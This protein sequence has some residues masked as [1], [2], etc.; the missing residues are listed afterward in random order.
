MQ[1]KGKVV[2]FE[3]SGNFYLKMGVKLLS[4]Q[5]YLEAANFFRKAISLEPESCEYHFNLAGALAE[6]GNTR[7]SVEILEN[8]IKKLTKVMPECYFAL[9]CNYFDLG[10]FEKSKEMFKRYCETAP[11][12][13]F[14]IEAT[15]AV[16]FI[17]LHILNKK[18]PKHIRLQ[19]LANKGKELLDKYEFSKAVKVLNKVIEMSP[20]S[21]VPRNNLS[22]AYYLQGEVGNA[23]NA[24]REVL[25]L[26]SRN[27]YANSNLAL[28][29]K[30]IDSHDL[31]KRQLAAVKNA[32]FKTVEEILNTVDILSK[33][34]ED[35]LIKNIMENIVKSHDEIILW[36]FLAIS[37]HNTGRYNKSIEVW[38]HIKNR[39]P[40]MSIFTDCFVME[41]NK[42]LKN[43]SATG[44]I[45]YDVKVFADYIARIEELIE[46]L[47]NMEQVEFNRIWESNDYVKDIVNHF[48][49]KLENKKKLKLIE[50]LDNADDEASIHMLNAYIKNT[51]RKDEVSIKC[52]EIVMRRR[53]AGDATVNIVEFSTKQ[54]SEKK[55]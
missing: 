28:F 42:Y 3:R 46:V 23:I 48:L 34:N 37:Y 15:E 1:N 55:R 32:D 22:L 31:Y 38:N 33:L 40:H 8:A 29:Y 47:I 45:N 7:E 21:T 20:E 54:R 4:S 49:Y 25:R 24:A 50:K 19:K 9:G 43:K 6:A 18:D 30:T 52:E 17:D 44:S 16:K 11:Q 39:L 41:S 53:V 13:S 26:D 35:C 51:E 10:N 36:H 27:A 5:R 2:A 14:F 12:G